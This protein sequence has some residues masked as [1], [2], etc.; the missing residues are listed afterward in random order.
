MLP[1]GLGL[2]AVT[3]ADDPSDAISRTSFDADQGI[4][5]QHTANGLCVKSARSLDKQRRIGFARQSE[6]L[7]GDT[8]ESAVDEAAEADDPQDF[9]TVLTGR[10]HGNPKA[11]NCRR[12]LRSPSEHADTVGGLGDQN[13]SRCKS[14]MR[15]GDVRVGGHLRPSTQLVAQRRVGA[16]LFGE[17]LPLS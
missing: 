11:P 14:E 1:Q 8:I 6:L 4:L 5:E 13:R 7:D 12:L 3:D 17:P 10:G 9:S 2:L 15:V 16:L